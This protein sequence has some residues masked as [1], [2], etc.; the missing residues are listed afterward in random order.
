[1]GGT[2]SLVAGR[3]GATGAAE[4]V[5][6]TAR[7]RFP[8]GLAWDGAEGLYIADTANHVVRRLDLRSHRT[9]TVAG[10]A[11]TP[12]LQDGP[13]TKS[14]LRGPLGLAWDPAGQLW[15]A[16]S[17]NG[18]LRRLAVASGVLSTPL[19][20][21]AELRE[22]AG[23]VRAGDRLYLTDTQGS[24]VWQV[25][26]NGGPA[27]VLAGQP[28]SPGEVDGLGGAARFNGP[29]GLALA[30]DGAL[31]VSDAGGRTLRRI[32]RG[33]GVVTTLP[34]AGV[35]LGQPRGLA[36]DGP[37]RLLIADAV[38]ETVRSLDLASGRLGLL[39]GGTAQPGGSDGMGTQARLR[40]P[41][42]LAAGNGG[43]F[44]TDAATVRSL[45]THGAVVTLAGRDEGAGDVDGS[46]TQA[47]FHAP[48]GLASD[49]HG[50]L[51][52][53]DSANGSV[54]R[55]DL[56]SGRTDT[57][58]SRAK[59]PGARGLERPLAIALG[60]GA[61]Y[62][63]DGFA[64]RIHRLDLATGELS[65]L[66]GSGEAGSKD[67]RAGAAQFCG[68]LALSLDGAG[69]LWVADHGYQDEH[70]EIEDG[71]AGEGEDDLPAPATRP[72][73]A[74]IRR[75]DLTSG[76]VVT[77]AGSGSEQAELDGVGLAARFDGPTALACDGHR[78]FIADAHGATVRVLSLTDLSVRTLAGRDGLHGTEDGR[79]EKARFFSPLGLSLGR[80]NELFIAEGAV[81]TVRRL[82]LATGEVSTWLGRAGV[83][84]VALSP[85]AAQLNDPVALIFS[86]GRLY[87]AD[88]VENAV[89]SARW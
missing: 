16:D 80:P 15:I 66:A 22:P 23:L 49:G 24:V 4:G 20:P 34:A 63:A 33:D 18:A 73:C 82:D 9:K 57:V 12:G 42:A 70:D 61:L 68:P 2:L 25:G 77:V 69:H 89:L 38:D 10:Q 55:I 88:A 52:V 72:G 86:G 87:I 51:F 1:M 5:G 54:R 75:V 13:P 48:S 36:L 26:V 65:T 62:I 79:A 28:G 17:G 35:A 53:A 30:P 19:G 78:L 11:G 21:G 58:A 84:G 64:H 71:A 76:E 6:E 29:F 8:G 41:N 46:P 44:L 81:G 37:G 74:A 50:T 14:L 3:L 67:G 7:F 27:T 43:F 56:T 83:T 40:G 45:S 47:R 85:A 59:S 31:Y 32:T 60:P 39:A